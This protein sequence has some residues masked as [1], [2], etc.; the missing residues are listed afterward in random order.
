MHNIYI[1]TG[2]GKEGCFCKSQP[3][4]CGNWSLI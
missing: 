4:N 1:L 2:K 3:T